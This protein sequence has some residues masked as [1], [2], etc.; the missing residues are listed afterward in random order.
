M[1]NYDVLKEDFKGYL[2]CMSKPFKFLMTPFLC[3]MF[4]F[5]FIITFPL[6]LFLSSSSFTKA[7]WKC[8]HMTEDI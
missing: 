6:L 7:M 1:N 5:D 4:P 3:L 2:R 8:N